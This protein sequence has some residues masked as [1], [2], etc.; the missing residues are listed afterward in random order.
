MK[1]MDLFSLLA[2]TYVFKLAQWYHG[3]CQVLLLV[4]E[5]EGDVFKDWK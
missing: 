2:M 3:L 1:N 4:G 5:E